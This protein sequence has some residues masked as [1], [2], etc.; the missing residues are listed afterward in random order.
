MIRPSRMRMQLILVPYLK[1]SSCLRKKSIK[2]I[3]LK[4]YFR[5]PFLNKSD[6]KPMRALAENVFLDCMT[7]EPDEIFYIIATISARSYDVTNDIFSQ[8]ERLATPKHWIGWNQCGRKRQAWQSG[9]RRPSIR[10]KLKI[11]YDMIFTPI[12]VNKTRF[13]KIPWNTSL[14]VKSAIQWT[15]KA[16]SRSSRPSLWR[17]KDYWGLH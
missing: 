11:H 13:W 4:F 9:W 5:I 10:L 3:E 6:L 15:W 2:A 16:Y 17:W 7:K 12:L 1:A 8:F 14:N